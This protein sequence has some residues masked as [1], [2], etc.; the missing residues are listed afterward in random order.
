MGK[1]AGSPMDISVVIM[2][3]A[4]SMEPE[5]EPEPACETGMVSAYVKEDIEY[6]LML[7][8]CAQFCTSPQALPW[9]AGV[10]E[11][12]CADAGY[13]IFVEEQTV[14][15]AGSPMDISVVIMSMADSMEPEP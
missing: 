12:A 10:E 7:G 4:D 6:G 2:S 8:Q 11:G 5:P 1:P 15:P 14:K 9:M 3:M 13:M